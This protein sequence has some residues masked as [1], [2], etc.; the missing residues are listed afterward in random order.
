MLNKF[1]VMILTVSL[2]T[3]AGTSTGMA[4]PRGGGGGNGG[5]GGKDKHEPVDRAPLSGDEIS[6][7]MFMREEEKVARDSYLA[8]G[9]VWG[10][11]IFDNIASSEQSHMDALKVLIDRYELT[12]PV[13][14]GVGDF[15]DPHLQ[16]LYDAL[17]FWG[18]KSLMDSLYVGAVIEETDMIDIQHA[19]DDTEHEDIISTYETLMCGSRN[20]LRAFARQIEANGGLYNPSDE[21]FEDSAQ[22]FLDI[23]ESSMERDCADQD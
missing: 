21:Y 10:L 19:I 6:G 9:G 11:T 22:Y 5:G 12:D 17:V 18:E 23:A 16:Q 20:H 14:P 13:I 1:L 7:L 15:T 3:V 2:I 4:G 8:L